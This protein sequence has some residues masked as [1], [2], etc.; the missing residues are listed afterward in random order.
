MFSE[1]SALFEKGINSLTRVYTFLSVPVGWCRPVPGR[2]SEGAPGG[3]PVPV[4]GKSRPVPG[5]MSIGEVHP[6]AGRCRL[7]ARYLSN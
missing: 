4:A 1:P 5:C 6:V 2:A 7:P 3:R